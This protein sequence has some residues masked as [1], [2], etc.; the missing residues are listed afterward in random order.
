MENG[1]NSGLDEERAELSENSPGDARVASSDLA[2]T[3]DIGFW[4]WGLAAPMDFRNGT[5]S[6]R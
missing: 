1:G 2:H 5:R 6:V 3:H 4:Y